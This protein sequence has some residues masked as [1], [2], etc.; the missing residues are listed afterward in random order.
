M[1]LVIL[2]GT[3]ARPSAALELTRRQ[4]DLE[5]GLID[6]NPPGR[7]QTDKRRPV[8][9][10]CRVLRTWIEAADDGPLAHYLGR[11]IEYPYQTWRRV[12]RAARLPEEF[13]PG[14]LR[15]T[16]ASM[17]RRQ[18][19]PPAQIAGFLGHSLPDF[20]TTE[21]YAKYDPRFMAETV[22]ALDRFFDGIA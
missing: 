9:P 4:C 18:G 6:L 7:L 3:A 12:R 16:V 19:V 11:P 21:R 13:T 17:L 1:L 10:M 5:N 14:C 22:E 15:H 2:L 8:I 20:R